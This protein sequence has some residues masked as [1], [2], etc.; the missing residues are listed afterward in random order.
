MT[1]VSGSKSRFTPAANARSLS[2]EHRLR[3]ARCTATSDDEQAVS[4]ASDVDR[5]AQ[6]LAAAGNVQ[7]VSEPG[8]L[9]GP[10]GGYGFRIFDPDGRVLELSTISG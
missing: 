10:G 9:D 4:T 1:V 6:R 8:K 7:L 3:Q 5:L 2:P